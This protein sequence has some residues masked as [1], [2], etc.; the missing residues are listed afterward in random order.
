MNSTPPKPPR[1]DSDGRA[2]PPSAPAASSGEMTLAERLAQK[3]AQVAERFF[4][5]ESAPSWPA[6]PLQRRM[7]G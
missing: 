1:P 3:E 7:Q 4:A 2:N 5:S 6:S